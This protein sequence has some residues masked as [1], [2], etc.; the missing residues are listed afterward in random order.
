MFI[1]K[2]F[3]GMV[4]KKQNGCWIWIGPR[5]T[6]GYG[7]MRRNGTNQSSHRISYEFHFGEIPI[8]LLVCHHCDTPLCVNP[9][10]LFLGTNKDNMQDASKKGRMASGDRHHARLFPERLARGRSHFSKTHPELVARGERCSS[11]KLT[12]IDVKHMR[13]LRGR[14]FTL[15]SLSIQFGVSIPCVYQVTNCKTWRHVK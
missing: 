7:Y 12:V 13:L 4:K 10:H 8:G 9:K 1:E 2:N 6:D 3:W 15:K 5:R 14:G 11:S